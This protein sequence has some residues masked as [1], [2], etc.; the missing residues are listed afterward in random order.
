MAKNWTI[1]EAFAEIEKGNAESIMD[2]GKRFPLATNLITRLTVIKDNPAVAQFVGLLPDY[3]TVG[4]LNTV[5]KEGVVEETES[6]DADVEKESKSAKQEKQTK[7]VEAKETET[8]EDGEDFENMTGKQLV[9]KIKSAGLS[10]VMKKDYENKWNKANMI[11]CLKNNLNAAETEAEDEAEDEA[12]ENEYAGKTAKELFLMCKK[13]GIKVEP[14][15][16]AKFYESALLKDD[17]K[18]K[19]ADDED[20]WGEDEEETKSSKKVETKKT[21]KKA[22]KPKKDEDEETDEW[23]I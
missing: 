12:A 9:D 15:K 23:D 16:P 5:L 19:E 4:K 11:D 8:A 17:S 14:K 6:E 10:M 2:L 20:D 7:K 3:N 21:E 1:K 13:R 22:S 18:K